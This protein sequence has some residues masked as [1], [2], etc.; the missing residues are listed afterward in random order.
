MVARE[1]T[2]SINFRI[3]STSKFLSLNAGSYS[4]PAY[5]YEEGHKYQTVSG[6]LPINYRARV[7][8]LLMVDCRLVKIRGGMVDRDGLIFD[9]YLKK[10]DYERIKNISGI[11]NGDGCWRSYRY[12]GCSPAGR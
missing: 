2:I 8:N 7:I 11:S 5:V 1:S 6:R 12:I 3:S 4:I 10:H 9:Y